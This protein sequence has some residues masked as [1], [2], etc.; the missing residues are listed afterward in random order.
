MRGRKSKIRNI[1]SSKVRKF[2]K[3][4]DSR[5]RGGGRNPW[6]QKELG[7]V[8]SIRLPLWR[9]CGITHGARS[10]TTYFYNLDILMVDP[11]FLRA[12]VQE[13]AWGPSALFVDSSNFMPGNITAGTEVIDHLNLLP[14][15]GD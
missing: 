12:L 9:G 4:E 5:V 10:P 11:H 1:D 15:Y 3:I 2:E 8:R 13:W 14:V 7:K 6:P